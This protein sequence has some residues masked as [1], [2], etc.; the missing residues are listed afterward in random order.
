MNASGVNDVSNDYMLDTAGD[1]INEEEGEGDAD[2]VASR[3][4]VDP[5]Y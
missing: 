1:E 4:T 5:V 2:I 3:L